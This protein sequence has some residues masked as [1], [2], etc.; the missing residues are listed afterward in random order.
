MITRRSDSASAFRRA[1]LQQN[2]SRL[3]S[4][5]FLF[6]NFKNKFVFN[7]G[8]W[9]SLTNDPLDISRHFYLEY[10][11]IVSEVG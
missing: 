9:Y 3:F 8:C 1:T 4:D 7:F 11:T 6:R 2:P 5:E 10:G